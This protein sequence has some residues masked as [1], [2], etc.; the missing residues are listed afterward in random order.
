[1]R[2]RWYDPALS[3]PKNEIPAFLEIKMKKGSRSYKFRKKLSFSYDWLNGVPLENDDLNQITHEHVHG[4]EEKVPLNLFAMLRVVYSRE[5]FVCS[6]TGARISLDTLIRSDLANSDF[7][8]AT[9]SANLDNI[10]L[11]IKDDDEKEIP[12][13]EAL[14]QSGFRSQSFSKY[15][16]C[17]HKILHGVH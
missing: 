1:V 6:L 9:S 4:L 13:L 17:M 12:W 11:E 15:G 5:R 2:L 14:F 8:P 10:V 16:M 7:L 3:D